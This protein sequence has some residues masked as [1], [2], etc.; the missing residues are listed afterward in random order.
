MPSA[1]EIYEQ[2]KRADEA[3]PQSFHT[4]NKLRESDE[5]LPEQNPT[6]ARNIYMEDLQRGDPGVVKKAFE[7]EKIDNPM[8]DTEEMSILEKTL[9]YLSRGNYMAANATLGLLQGEGFTDVSKRAFAGLKGEAKVSFIDVMDDIMGGRNPWVNIPVGFA[10]DVIVDPINLIPL[11]WPRKFAELL[12]IPQFMKA[13]GRVTKAEKL[14]KRTKDVVGDLP[15]INWMGKAF[16]PGY[17]LR[18]HP[19]AYDAYRDV[20]LKIASIKR[21]VREELEKRWDLFREASKKLGVDAEWAAAEMIRGHEAGELEKGLSLLRETGND[22]VLKRG[23]MKLFK[24]TSDD[25]Q[26][27]GVMKKSYVDIVEGFKKMAKEE[28]EKGILSNVI[29]NYFPHI[30]EKGTLQQLP[31]GKWKAKGR[32]GFFTSMRYRGVPF[33]A[34]AR[35]FNSIESAKNWLAQYAIKGHPIPVPVEH[36]FR[37]YAIRKFVGESALAW[38]DFVQDSLQKFGTPI[39]NLSS[40]AIEASI[41]KGHRMVLPTT[42]L[43]SPAARNLADKMLKEGLGIGPDEL[44]KIAGEHGPNFLYHLFKKTK[45]RGAFIDVDMETVKKLGKKGVYLLPTEIADNIK[46]SFKIFSTDETVKGFL[47]AFDAGLQMW[48][49]MATS[50]RLPFHMRNAISNTWLMYLGGVKT[51]MMAKRISQALRVQLGDEG[52]EF[53]GWSAKELNEIANRYGVRAFG[54]IGADVPR[55]FQKELFI[56]TERGARARKLGFGVHPTNI[57]ETWSRVGRK[58]GTGV[59]DSARLGLFIDR[60]KKLGLTKATASKD[61]L[62]KAAEHVKKYLFDYTELTPF[63]RNVMKRAMPF[64]TWMRKNIPRQL[65]S[66]VRHPEKFARLADVERD[67]FP[68]FTEPETPSEKR[69]R[70]SWLDEMRARKI[71]GW[72]TSTGQPIYGWIDLPTS[73]L[74][75]IQ[76]LGKYLQSSVNPAIVLLDVVRNVRTWPKSGTLGKPGVKVP[77]PFYVQFLPQKDWGVLG[78]EPVRNRKTGKTVLGMDPQWKYALNTA[79][80]FLNDW[81]KIHPGGVSLGVQRE[82]EAFPRAISYMTGIKFL[83]VNQQDAALQKYYKTKDVMRNIRRAA[84]IQKKLT[85]EEINEIFQETLQ[86]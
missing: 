13:A 35:E 40:E 10:A 4:V 72:E 6:S 25:P 39:V 68:I 18:K 79:F 34:K 27:L 14:V 20:E 67:L 65:A 24:T 77:A 75:K 76:K 9:D 29:D 73:D 42:S 47:G 59:E 84:K 60:L 74:H 80:P 70:P 3:S 49:S 2:D 58:F 57:F 22:E 46:D 38:K 71:K 85:R 61:D 41:A 30:Y 36:W 21:N 5:T 83:P 81:E 37:G 54:W 26:A 63:E 66:I 56:S 44:E 45:G 53:A 33:H 7:E 69:V 50:M 78:I 23:L 16:K 12:K 82:G 86:E 11:S 15:G 8:M 64:Y 62:Y 28:S 17:S 48:K 43:R 32:Y 31:G 1:F 19:G 52:F 55:M 51:P